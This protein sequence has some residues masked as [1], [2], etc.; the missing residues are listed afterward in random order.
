[1]NFDWCEADINI[2]SSAWDIQ[3]F[4]EAVVDILCYILMLTKT[5]IFCYK[6]HHRP[7]I[8]L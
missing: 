4:H 6:T 5:L 2:H 8:V 3:I 7:V 1:M